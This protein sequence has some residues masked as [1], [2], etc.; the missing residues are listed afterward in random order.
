MFVTAVFC[1]PSHIHTEYGVKHMA[2]V[3]IKLLN[4]F[5]LM[6]FLCIY[7]SLYKETDFPMSLG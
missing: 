7:L 4:K 1:H 2:V 6:K 3:L 5:L